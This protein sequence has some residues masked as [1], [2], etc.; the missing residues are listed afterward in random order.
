[1]ESLEDLLREMSDAA[2]R[3]RGAYAYADRY[4]DIDYRADHLADVIA[5]YS[6]LTQLV[7]KEN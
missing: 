5:R 6:A 2:D 1:M 7:T 4:H 3:L